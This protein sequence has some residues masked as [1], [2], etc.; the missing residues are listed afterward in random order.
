MDKIFLIIGVVLAP[1]TA[2]SFLY[3]AYCTFEGIYEAI[4][5]VLKSKE[6]ALIIV[7]FIFT[8]WIISMGYFITWMYS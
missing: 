2:A 8:I 5:S 7:F 6:L 1:V 4:S 3:G